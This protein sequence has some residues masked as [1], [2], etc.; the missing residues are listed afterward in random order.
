M[1]QIILALLFLTLTSMSLAQSVD[2][3]SFKKAKIYLNNHRIIKVN[4]LK[5]NSIE[6]S[7]LNSINNKNEKVL[8]NTI[9]FIRIPKG[10]HL[11]EGA[12]YGAG[13]MALTAVLIDAQ[14][15]VLGRSQNKDAGFYLGFTAGGAVIGGFIG[16]LFPK[17]K[18]VY[19][20]GKFIGQNTRVKLNFSTQNDN[21]NIKITLSI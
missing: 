5:I 16:W 17:W 14:P 13:T 19:S 11:W 2:D 3:H 1:K 10:S 7:F 12:L 20:G 4:N 21:V 6:A 18:S 8:M 9:K 15:D